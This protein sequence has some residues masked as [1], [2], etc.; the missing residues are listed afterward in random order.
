[1]AHTTDCHHAPYRVG[2]TVTRIAFVDCFG[3][4]QPAIPGLVVTS[5]LHVHSTS[6]LHPLPAYWRIFASNPRTRETGEGAARYFEKENES[7]PKS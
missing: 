4:A 5:V 2:D 3:R 6:R 1:M 7:C